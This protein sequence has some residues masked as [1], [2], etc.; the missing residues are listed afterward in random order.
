M[1]INLLPSIS[2]VIQVLIATMQ[3]NLFLNNSYDQNIPLYSFLLIKKSCV[4]LPWDLIKQFSSI[5]G[6]TCL[7]ISWINN[8]S[9]L[10]EFYLPLQKYLPGYHHIP[11]MSAHACKDIQEVVK[12]KHSCGTVSNWDSIDLAFVLGPTFID[13]KTNIVFLQMV[14]EIICH[15]VWVPNQKSCKVLLVCSHSLWQRCVSMA[16]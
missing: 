13:G 7:D 4:T 14:N 8:P 10:V 11:H 2:I 9:A 5:I 6:Q 15:Y 3:S 1:D 12:I 16:F